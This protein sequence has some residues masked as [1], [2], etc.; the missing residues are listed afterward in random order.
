[1]ASGGRGSNHKK[2]EVG[3]VQTR[4]QSRV[5]NLDDN[6]SFQILNNL[7]K[8]RKKTRDVV[9]GNMEQQNPSS[10]V[11]PIFNV[12]KDTRLEIEPNTIDASNKEIVGT[13]Q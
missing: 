6:S 13:K 7:V 5:E 4:S 2:K 1:M 9:D 3:R 12:S 11:Q 8:P 10:C